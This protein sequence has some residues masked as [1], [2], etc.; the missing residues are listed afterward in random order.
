MFGVLATSLY[1]SSCPMIAGVCSSTTMT[2][3]GGR[4]AW[5]DGVAVLWV[6]VVYEPGPTLKYINNKN[7]LNK[8]T[9]R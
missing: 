8:K 5:M 4:D 2:C 9:Q 3:E 6:R 7:Q 1:H